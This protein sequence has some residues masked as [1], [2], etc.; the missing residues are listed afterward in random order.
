MT[1]CR[2]C[3][4]DKELMNSHA[5]PDAIFRRLFREDSG[6]AI[7]FRI[8][9]D[10]PVGF[11]NDSWSEHQLCSD[12]E[13]LINNNYEKYAISLIRGGEGNVNKSQYGISFSNI[14]NNRLILFLISILWRAA[15]SN[16]PAYSKVIL[17]DYVRDVMKHSIFHAKCLPKNLL[18][19]EVSRLKDF[20]GKNGFSDGDLKRII[21]SPF[22]RA[23]DNKVSFCYLLEGFFVEIFFP[24]H[25]FK[26]SKRLN[27]VRQ[28]GDFL[29]APYIDVFSVPELFEAM[30]S[31][32]KKFYQG[33]FRNGLDLH[34]AERKQQSR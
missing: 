30:K 32:Y 24:S 8:D 7:A 29:N 5:I 2:L 4:K 26:C 1:I 16:D 28:N 23:G 19:I 10:L 21:V 27:V 9:E 14:E 18:S 34:I 6:K 20:S 22:Y 12:C 15:E 3:D 31:G 11:S 13:K 25:S 17:P 33:N